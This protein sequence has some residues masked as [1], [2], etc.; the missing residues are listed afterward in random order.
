[1]ACISVVVPLGAGDQ[2]TPELHRFLRALDSKCFQLIVSVGTSKSLSDE[3]YYDCLRGEGFQIVSGLNGRGKQLNRG[4]ES[5]V[6]SHLWFLHGDSIVGEC[7]H[8]LM[9]LVRENKS[10]LYYFQLKFDRQF[11]SLMSVNEFG[12]KI[13]SNLL[14]LPFGDQGFFIKKSL[15]E[16]LGRFDEDVSYGEDHMFVWA[17]HKSGIPVVS[18]QKSII[19]SSR[20]YQKQGWLPTTLTHLQLTAK[21]GFPEL[22]E[23]L[24]DQYKK[25]LRNP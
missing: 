16:S 5:A 24:Q 19:T 10:A 23:L 25:L 7:T 14:K 12:V 6:G 8:R 11:S 9:E 1:M 15:F 18:L 13:R 21:Q 3:S 17:C 4:A 2:L 22:R 20:K